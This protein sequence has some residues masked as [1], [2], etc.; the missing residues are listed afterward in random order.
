MK[1]PAQMT[2]S[3]INDDLRGYLRATGFAENKV[4]TNFPVGTRLALAVK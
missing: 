3:F 4:S 2:V 1:L